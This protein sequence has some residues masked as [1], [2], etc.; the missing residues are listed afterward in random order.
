VGGA[1]HGGCRL[2][3]TKDLLTTRCGCAEGG[4]GVGELSGAEKCGYWGR[5]RER[6]SGGEETRSRRCR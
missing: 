1:F 5:P 6:V 3:P 4:S 2:R